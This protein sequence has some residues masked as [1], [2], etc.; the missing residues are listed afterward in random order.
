MVNY[1]ARIKRKRL[2]EYAGE[3]FRDENAAIVKHLNNAGKKALFGIQQADGMYTIVGE[4][5]VYYLSPSGKFGE[6]PLGDFLKLLK[7]HAYR[8]GRTGVFDFLPID[9][10]EQVWLKDARTMSVMWGIMSLLDDFNNG[11]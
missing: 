8:L 4:D 2:D 1:K 3:A 5:T 10:S 7:D 11:K 6:I 9:D